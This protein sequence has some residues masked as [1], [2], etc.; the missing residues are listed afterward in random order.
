LLGNTYHIDGKQL[1]RHYKCHLSDF[2]TWEQKFHAEKWLLFP[3]NIGKRLSLDETAFSDGELYT[4]L[5]NKDRHGGY[6]QLQ[7]AYSVAH[8]LRMI[9]SKNFTKLDGKQAI[10]KW[11]KKAKAL[12]LHSFNTVVKT[13]QI[14]EDEILNYFTNR[15]TNA[16]AESFNAKIKFFRA[17]L[18]GVF[19]C[20]FALE[21]NI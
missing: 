2:S 17:S 6:P 20:T 9:Y 8:S 21:K 1:E 10:N 19:F 11:Y 12:D 3:E 5:T 16:S 13:I 14:N 7:K 18:R 4:F 15:S